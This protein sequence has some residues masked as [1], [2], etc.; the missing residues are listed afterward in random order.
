MAR[1]RGFSSRSGGAAAPGSTGASFGT[2][3]S[4]VLSA[5]D[6]SFGMPVWQEGMPPLDSEL[7]LLSQVDWERHAQGI[8]AQM[9]SGFFLDPTR[10]GAMYQ[11]NTNWS[12]L[13]AFGR[14]KDVTGGNESSEVAPFLWANVNGWVL[15]ITG[16]DVETEGDLRNFVKLYPSPES[17][18]RVDFVFLEVWHALV[19]ANPSE[20]NK[21][22]A[23][24][25]YKYGNVLYGGTN[26]SDDLTWNQIG[27]E[28][29][30][31]VQVQ[32]RIRVFGS[33]AG[34]GSG[35]ALDVYPE[36]LGDPNILGQGTNTSPVGGFSFENMRE[37]LGDPG[38]WRAGDGDPT[39]DLG[40]VDG[41][42][43]AI[44]ICAVFRR[45]SGAYV[46][47]TSAGN[48]NQNGAF[49]RNPG[50]RI[51]ANPLEASRILL[52]ASL[53]S[54]L[55]FD[56]EGVV[57]ITNLNGSG[58]EAGELTL[59]NTFIVIDGEVIGISAVDANAETVTI[60]AGGRG[61][62]G[63]AA[64]GHAAGAT[65]TFYSGRPDGLF[66][67]QIA[68]T[69]IMD[70]CHA[71]NPG[72]WDYTRLL[73]YGLS[74]LCTGK[75][76][77]TW[78]ESA[79]GDT[80]GVVVHEVSYLLADGA[81]AV[82][83]HTEALDGPDGI[84]TVWSDAAMI[85]SDVTVL[86][87]NDATLDNNGVGLSTSDQFDTNVRWDVGA[88]L[89]PT[90]F[91]NVGAASGGFANGSSIFLH[92][93]GE[94]GSEGARGT[95]RDGS[96]KAVRF[97]TPKEYWLANSYA[98]PGSKQ[99]PVSAR[100][101]PNRAHEP[102]PPNV[103]TITDWEETQHPGPMVPVWE[104]NFEKPFIV[105]GGL[106]EPTLQ[107]SVAATEFTTPGTS[108]EID[109]GLNFDTAGVFYSLD[110]DGQFAM[111]ATAVSMPLLR[112]ERTL[113]DLLTNGG[114]DRTGLSSEVYV[115]AYGDPDSTNNNGAFKVIGAGTV[116]YTGAVASNAT[117][118]VVLPLST[119]F[120]DFNPA[121]GNTLTV[122]FRS[123]YHN[124]D[125]PSDYENRVADLCVVL[126][127]IGGLADH[128][129]NKELL[130]DGTAYD[131]AY[132]S[133]NGFISGTTNKVLVPQ[134]LLLNLSLMY[135]PGRSG[136]A[137]IADEIVRVASRS[138]QEDHL[139]NVVSDIDSTFPTVLDEVVYS[140]QPIQTWNR[141]SALG[142][143]APDAVAM[144]GDLVS[145][146]EIDRENQVF[147]D[148]AS[149]T[150]VYRPFRDR[151]MT[152]QAMSW[153]G[154]MTGCLLGDYAYPSTDAKDPLVIWTGTSSTG[155]KM[156]FPVPKE[157]MPRF[158]RQDI[159]YRVDT[160][161]G[162]GRFLSG[163]NHL[164]TDKVDPTDPVF[165]IIGGRDNGTAGNEVSLF[166]FVTGTPTNYGVSDVV[167]GALNIPNIEARKTTD[168]DPLAAYADEVLASLNGVR[169]SDFG[170]G[171]KG[172][173]LPPYYGPARILGVYE[174]EDFKSKGGRT[175][176]S[177]RWEV[178][179][180]PATNLLREDA[181]KFTLYILENGA[182]DLTEEDGDHTYIIPSH[183]L[184]VTRVPGYTNESFEDYDYVVVCS[185]FGFAKNWING[186][187]L[188][189]VRKH[190]GA[191]TLRADTTT[192]ELEGVG[193]CI[194]CPASNNEPLYVAYNRT[195]YQGDVYGT[196]DGDTRTMSDY[197][198][199]YGEIPV[200][201]AFELGTSI[202]QYDSNG[203]F[204]P[205]LA[206]TRV[207]E[208]LASTDFYTTL[209]TGKVAG[210]LQAGTVTDVGY[211]PSN[212]GTF[213]P[214][215]ADANTPRIEPRAFTEGQGRNTSRASGSFLVTNAEAIRDL[216]DSNQVARFGIRYGDTYVK[217]Y[218]SPSAYEATLTGA[219]VLAK[220]IITIPED[221][222][223][224]DRV[225]ETSLNFG[226]LSPTK[227]Y[228]VTPLQGVYRRLNPFGSQDDGS[229]IVT[230]KAEYK[231]DLGSVVFSGYIDGGA[232]YVQAHYTAGAQPFLVEDPDV[233]LNVRRFSLDFGSI[234]S[235]TSANLT[236]NWPGALTA[237]PM[238]VLV[239]MQRIT[240]GM[241]VTG[242]VSGADTITIT[243]HN[244]SSGSID[245]LS[246]EFD[247]A[248]VQ[249]QSLTAYNIDLSNVDLD[250]LI[251]RS[252]PTN[253]SLAAA[254]ATHI[255]NHE[256]LV[257][258]IDAYSEEDAKVV[259]TSNLP[260]LLGN[261]IA[262][263]LLVEDVPG[264]TT[265]P[266]Y[267]TSYVQFLADVPG[268]L[269][270]NTPT[271]V[272]NY[273]SRS[274]YFR[275]SMNLKGGVDLPVN[276]G[277][278]TST[279]ALT[280]MTERLPLGIL[281]Q[282]FNFLCEN[283]LGENTSSAF[284]CLPAAL[285]PVQTLLPFTEQGTEYTRFTG[286]PGSLIAMSD[287][288]ILAYS[289]YS[290]SNPTGSRRFRIYRGGGSAFVLDGPVPGG[291]VDWAS[292][293][294]AEA[295]KPVL[296]GALLA[297]K[298]LLVRNYYEEAWSSDT[299][300]SHGDEVQLLILTYGIPGDREAVSYSLG[301]EISPSGYGEGYAAVDRYRLPARPLLRG[302]SRYVPN[303][304]AVEIAP[305]ED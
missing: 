73:E 6:R 173:Q 206:N 129:W 240:P 155:K 208:V 53:D 27:F 63:T 64:A 59:A 267:A 12:N 290:S 188:V 232:L 91:M 92:I 90:G 70:M 122:E 249:P 135:H 117:S 242:V 139:Q 81:T 127:D 21:P 97:V 46:A 22:S 195:V 211:S 186:N 7:N 159:P 29:T 69:D 272:P 299:P 189:L 217:L 254:I 56:D 286:A 199:R 54:D 98:D 200:A 190:N 78:K 205:Q 10:S 289:A 166:H 39:N 291:P 101:L 177:N 68:E 275:T 11:T 181:H 61:R 172:I 238:A 30:K 233:G 113:Y 300:V 191:G 215:A 269:R 123:Q 259:L 184:D 31:R 296:K 162:A 279:M 237:N 57:N 192:F 125:D 248:L 257:S 32:Y 151:D 222:V 253:E 288:K 146:T 138:V 118:I 38:L 106:L 41:Y 255:E 114:Q 156:G 77:S 194:P 34:L 72:D 204:L 19:G 171:L 178:A 85:Q 87:D 96:T 303:P 193:M 243:A 93:G 130:G 23:S 148:K 219:G 44:P 218:M 71:I 207:F 88:D 170:P 228:T 201:S 169:S 84:R 2:R 241:M 203:D 221:N 28:T 152:L 226:T 20:T 293:D 182:K 89:R 265:V 25:I 35:V 280:G 126:T 230:P 216:T 136:T 60:P 235:G 65:V 278:G 276:A 158:G 176:N 76:Q 271:R 225:E 251:A 245:M 258:L 154:L 108:V 120:V 187:N 246:T 115:V 163:I 167:I 224:W 175:F 74:S 250:I 197:E 285:A 298:A 283:P 95:F 294:L 8:R 244:Y 15:P 179:N 5:R 236:V 160:E 9:P 223:V 268:F 104:Q 49:D 40:T 302:H 67:D 50:A 13:F 214:G 119:D 229:V 147:F 134:K 256:D 80:E 227:P 231:T 107:L 282:D 86:L 284:K 234:A 75:L 62:N 277:N 4:R 292:G 1:R 109:V 141:L 161:A 110:A 281:L 42:V 112:G 168:I 261:Q 131:L 103:D 133:A 212:N 33:G 260:G 287:G 14:P 174:L 198:T 3:V 264:M 45:N 116:G 180:D 18:S 295:D 196:R 247:V 140:P 48:P 164:F 142:L 153:D 297:C 66:A 124:S 111:D 301:G 165:N 273:N 143:D 79:V 47:V 43:Y 202:Q 239:S 100:F 270:R 24:T 26:V 137:R 210:T 105:L 121:T 185:V 274:P 149:K 94:T 305:Y 132:N 58:L 128:P 55:A 36:G 82:P 145:R 17:D 144:G 252:L 213:L 37:A 220:N 157:F 52:E 209:G 16:T 83:N 266:G 262:L 150:L 102:A 99:T 263:D 304:D 183:T 51:L